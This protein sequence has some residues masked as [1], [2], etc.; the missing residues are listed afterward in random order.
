MGLVVSRRSLILGVTALVAAPAL[1]R[2]TSL[3]SL[4]G[5]SLDPWDVT[6]ET[7]IITPQWAAHVLQW[8]HQVEEF[9]QT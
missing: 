5:S 9:I 2:A 7:M 4:R 6:Q 1:V 8:T 3:M